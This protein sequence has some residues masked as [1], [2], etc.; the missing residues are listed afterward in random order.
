MKKWLFFFSSFLICLFAFVPFKINAS[1]IPYLKGDVLAYCY[2]YDENNVSYNLQKADVSSLT[3]QFHFSTLDT[4]D[5]N[6]RVYIPMSTFQNPLADVSSVILNLNFYIGDVSIPFDEILGYYPYVGYVY[7][8]EGFDISSYTLDELTSPSVNHYSKMNFNSGVLNRYNHYTSGN[9]NII[10]NSSGDNS[11]VTYF[12]YAEDTI[13]PSY[14]GLYYYFDFHCPSSFTSF[15]LS[16]SQYYSVDLYTDYSISYFP[17]CPLSFDD[18]YQEGY[19]DGYQAGLDF[20][21]GINQKLNLR[22]RMS[23]LL[24]D[25][26]DSEIYVRPLVPET[27]SSKYRHFFTLNENIQ[28]DYPK[29]DYNELLY[30]NSSVNLT[31]LFNFLVSLDK[32]PTTDGKYQVLFLTP[33]GIPIPLGSSNV[34]FTFQ[35]L[36]FQSN[37]PLFFYDISFYQYQ[38]QGRIVKGKLQ[39]QFYSNIH[40]IPDS[41]PDDYFSSQATYENNTASIGSIVFSFSKSFPDNSFGF[42]LPYNFNKGNQASYNS[43]YD[44]GYLSGVNEALKDIKDKLQ[45][46]YNNGYQDGL[47]NAGLQNNPFGQVFLVVLDA[48]ITFLRKALD[49]NFFGINFYQISLSLV[50]ISLII[51]LLKKFL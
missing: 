13:P 45:N 30:N 17:I 36:Y 24:G 37:T 27:S 11:S 19:S 8:P 47:T 35:E 51:W 40:L 22:T 41:V 5:S 1:S 34:T 48:P 43:G 49:F 9:F 12:V 3:G 32:R 16:F 15:S 46:S 23:L 28:D 42:L 6:Y 14:D 29:F 25:L 33:S 2:S 7:P 20:S 21:G 50:S 38:P 18:R 26:L 44:A 10:Y 4:Y 39:E 31:Y